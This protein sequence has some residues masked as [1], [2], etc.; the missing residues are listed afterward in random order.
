VVIGFS[1]QRV[2]FSRAV[3]MLDELVPKF[4]EQVKQECLFPSPEALA[5][6]AA[7]KSLQC[8]GETKW[9]DLPN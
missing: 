3:K 4:G 1:L 8:K 2:S 9:K 7:W 5:G 6:A